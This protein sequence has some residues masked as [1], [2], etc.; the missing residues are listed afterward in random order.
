MND[1]VNSRY[2]INITGLLIVSI[3]GLF[4]Y[5]LFAMNNYKFDIEKLYLQVENHPDLVDVLPDEMG[6]S[7]PVPMIL[8]ENDSVIIHF[9]FFHFYMRLT[10][11]TEPREFN[12]SSPR[13]KT[14][15]KYPELT[16]IETKP[17]LSKVFG[18]DWDDS[19][20]IGKY[21]SDPSIPYE[22]QVEQ[23]K[24]FFKLYNSVLPLYIDKPAALNDSNKRMIK[25]F[26]ALF[27]DISH[28]PLLPYYKSLNPDFFS[29]LE[30]Y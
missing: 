27:Y 2:Q 18:V 20:P 7:F 14:I 12:I 23:E 15:V 19:K 29:W 4:P 1:H 25:E 16:I 6:T 26:R 3:I 21:V 17:A 13:H 10:K 30:Q 8:K 11:P 9:S 5:K 28:A 22:K 24:N